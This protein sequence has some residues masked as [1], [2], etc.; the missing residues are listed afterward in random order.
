[1]SVLTPVAKLVAAYAT[2]VVGEELESVLTTIAEVIP[3]L[4][5]S[6]EIV[7]RIGHA[8]VF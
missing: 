4:V 1:M 5:F 3:P 8:V 2:A 7:M 6:S